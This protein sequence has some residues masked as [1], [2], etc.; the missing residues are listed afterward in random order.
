M[1]LPAA[2]LILVLTLPAAASAQAL[3]PDITGVAPPTP[4]S[5]YNGQLV[6]SQPASNGQ[7][8]L[9]TRT[10]SGP[11]TPVPIATRA[12]PFDV[13]LGPTSSGT[14]YA[15]YSRCATEPEWGP[16]SMPP[17]QLGKG[18]MIYKFDFSANQEVKYSKV[19]ASNASQYWPS[20][21]KGKIAYGRTYA[22]NTN[23]GY[24]YSKTVASSTPSAQ[25]PIGA[26]GTQ[27]NAQ[28]VELNGNN[29]AFAWNYEAEP[30][31]Y[32]QLR[33]DKIGSK[34]S[35][36]LD[37]TRGGQSQVALGWP[38]FG[39]S[40]QITWLRYCLGDP[41]VCPGQ[42]RIQ[43]STFAGKSDQGSNTTEYV[44]AYDLDQGITYLENDV[45]SGYSCQTLAIPPT[46]ACTITATQPTFSPIGGS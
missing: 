28:Q 36:V 41:A 32:Y 10:G 13:D 37:Q 42:T 27:A 33:M 8:Q 25:M 15:V 22:S 38:A 30:Y 40:S 44:E 5:A 9:V 23:K 31:T 11:V 3:P 12:V 35:T 46:P 26:L 29:L 24:L 21:W 34:G 4:I 6:W 43:S 45:S 20:Y 18:C 7:Y 16:Y 17:Y 14:I 19:N 39:S 1:R 2:V